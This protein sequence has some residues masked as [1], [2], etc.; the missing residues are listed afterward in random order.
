MSETATFNINGGTVV[1]VNKTHCVDLP[2]RIDCQDKTVPF[3]L[4][5]EAFMFLAHNCS[6][7]T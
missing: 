3:S 6:L 2:T 5:N 4:A 1:D 7:S